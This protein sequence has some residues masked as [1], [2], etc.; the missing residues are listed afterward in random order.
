M[1]CQAHSLSEAPNARK[2]RRRRGQRGSHSSSNVH[3]RPSSYHGLVVFANWRRVWQIGAMR[4][5]GEQERRRRLRALR[6]LERGLS[7]YHRPVG[8]KRVWGRP[9]VHK[10]GEQRRIQMARAQS[11]VTNAIR[12]GTLP[13]LDGTIPCVDCGRPAQ[14][15]DHRA[16][17]KPL[18]VAPVCR[19]CNGRRGPAADAPQT[20][21]LARQFAAR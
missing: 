10:A 4:S 20:G 11:A 21:P 2:P 18:D 17:A 19:S 9:A 8:A 1:A 6:D 12:Q 13:R 15:Y 3:S 7:P 5:S 16:Y 14:C